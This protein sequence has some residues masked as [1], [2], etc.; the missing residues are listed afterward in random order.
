M[1]IYLDCVNPLLRLVISDNG[2]IQ[3]QLTI[4][5]E[6]NYHLLDSSYVVG[7]C[8]EPECFSDCKMVCFIGVKKCCNG[9]VSLRNGTIAIGVF[10]L[11]TYGENLVNWL[12]CKTQNDT[13][14]VFRSC[15]KFWQYCYMKTTHDL[16]KHWHISNTWGKKWANK[17]IFTKKIKTIYIYIYIIYILYIYGAHI[18]VVSRSHITTQHS[19]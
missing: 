11:V 5:R 14:Y 3:F 19:R 2:R 7:F 17:D 15:Y 6:R 12:A 16:Y 13:T 4:Q 1:T 18:L 9:S 10:Y 8:F